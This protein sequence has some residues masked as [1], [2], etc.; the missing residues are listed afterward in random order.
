MIKLSTVPIS[1]AWYC[2]ILENNGLEASFDSSG[3]IVFNYAPFKIISIKV[4]ISGTNL[5]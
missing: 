1:Q 3:A 4:R 5:Q 2:N